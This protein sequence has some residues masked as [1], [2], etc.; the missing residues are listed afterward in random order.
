V[1]T[2]HDDDQYAVPCLREVRTEQSLQE[3]SIRSS[4]RKQ[5]KSRAKADKYKR[6]Y[7][8]IFIF[9]PAL[10]LKGTSTPYHMTTPLPVLS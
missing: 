7:A 9:R 5:E 6:H 2:V 3:K 8:I 1:E 4:S 10:S